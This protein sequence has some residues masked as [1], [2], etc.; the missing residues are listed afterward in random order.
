MI[1]RG[2]FYF[3]GHLG[4]LRGDHGHQEL[5]NGSAI[6]NCNLKAEQEFRTGDLKWKMEHWIWTRVTGTWDSNCILETKAENDALE[7]RIGNWNWQ[8]KSVSV[9]RKTA[10]GARK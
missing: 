10:A 1:A 3:S 8:T 5:E 2:A 9:S 6:G 7:I 4:G